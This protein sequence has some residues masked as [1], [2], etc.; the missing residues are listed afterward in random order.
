M[1]IAVGLAK[2]FE[3]LS[4]V[5]YGLLQAHEHMDHIA[6]S[7]MIKGP[8]SLVALG[9]G[10]TSPRASP[11]GPWRAWRGLGP[12]PH[13]LRHSHRHSLARG[14]R[15]LTP[16]LG[17][18]RPSPTGLARPAARDHHDAHLAQYQR[19]AL[20]YRTLLW[21]AQELGIFVALAYLMVGGNTVVGA[22]G[23]SASPRLARCYAAGDL[24]GFR[25]L[26]AQLVAIGAGIGLAGLAV[27]F[28]AGH[29]ILTFL[30]RPEYAR[31]ANL[32]VWLMV[33]AA[34]SYIASLLGYGMTAARC[35]R[36]QLPLS[37]LCGG[38]SILTCT[39]L[40]PRFGLVGAAWACLVTLM[41]QTLGSVAINAH[42]L[43]K[44]YV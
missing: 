42:A 40:V 33:G 14:R 34:V 6:M 15:H 2:A 30:Y 22:L 18:S 7:M 23:Q 32:F 16:L 37:A 13:R 25:Q 4:D 43:R 29:E 11:G 36:S 9:V 20:L 21:R 31:F 19:P 27:S 41:V 35:F 26:L 3:S 39:V 17:H 38:V 28:V 10:L 12:A 1:I 8:L 44:G 5:F 24:Q